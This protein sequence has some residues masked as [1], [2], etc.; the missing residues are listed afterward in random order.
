MKKTIFIISFFIGNLYA[1]MTF[2]PNNVFR[3][4]SFSGPDPSY[5]MPNI[6][7]IIDEI[8][9]SRS[10]DRE[11]PELDSI[12]LGPVESVIISSTKNGILGRKKFD[13][14]GRLVLFKEFDMGEPGNKFTYEYDVINRLSKKKCY[15]RNFD[16]LVEVFEYKYKPNGRIDKITLYNNENEF[17]RSYDYLYYKDLLIIRDDE[18]CEK[19]YYNPG[20][21]D[22][23]KYEKWDDGELENF[24]E[25][26][27]D[28]SNRV[29]K[30]IECDIEGEK[31]KKA[32]F[33]YKDYKIWK[34][35]IYDKKNKLY[36]ITYEYKG[37]EVI[38]TSYKYY[39]KEMNILYRIVNYDQYNN[40]EKIQI[41]ENNKIYAIQYYYKYFD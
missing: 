37:D 21:E 16:E 3:F 15:D 27:Y 19:Y 2:M 4:N 33:E 6:R 39:T 18:D 31:E 30:K 40:I 36:Q 20:T 23:K 24:T 35:T 5:F 22:L 8:Q 17:E 32:I 28:D 34:K 26:F 12:F 7:D 9:K 41:N 29:V 13:K 11:T 10:S 1:Q 38:S 14:K 25:Y